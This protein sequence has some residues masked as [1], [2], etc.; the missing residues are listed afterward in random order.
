MGCIKQHFMKNAAR[1]LA[2]KHPDTLGKDFEVNKKT[3]K[4]LGII[5]SKPIRNR[6]AGYIVR[7]FKNK[8]F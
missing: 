4:E 7:V 8:V 6:I 1:D 5:K 2:K 3:L